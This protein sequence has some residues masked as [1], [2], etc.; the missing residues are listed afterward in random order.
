MATEITAIPNGRVKVVETTTGLVSYFT[1]ENNT[2]QIQGGNVVIVNQARTLNPDYTIDPAQVTTPA[3]PWTAET[4][5]D[6]LNTSP[7]FFKSAGGGG[8]GGIT[9]VD[10]L[11]PIT[12]TG[13]NPDPVRIENGTVDGDTVCWNAGSGFWV[14][15]SKLVNQRLSGLKSGIFNEAPLTDASDD[16]ATGTPT[17]K[18]AHQHTTLVPGGVSTQHING[19]SDGIGGGPIRGTVSSTVTVTETPGGENVASVGVLTLADR[20]AAISQKTNPVNNQNGS[21]SSTWT[22]SDGSTTTPY[23]RLLELFSLASDVATTGNA[24]RDVR[25]QAIAGKHA[26]RQEMVFDRTILVG[27]S[28]AGTSYAALQYSDSVGV[29]LDEY[30][31]RETTDEVTPVT[32]WT[33]PQ[34]AFDSPY[35]DGTRLSVEFTGQAIS[36]L[37]SQSVYIKGICF[38]IKNGGT[39]NWD[40]VFPH[41]NGTYN[42]IHKITNMISD[43][44]FDFNVSSGGDPFAL[45]FD[46]S[47]GSYSTEAVRVSVFVKR[48]YTL[49]S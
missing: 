36:T 18:A 25:P 39:G 15:D 16:L 41:L 20:L 23:P 5:S 13:V 24:R 6:W 35:P 48:I 21:A 42:E 49:P 33:D 11:T 12:G 28:Q 14:I 8:G 2:A 38:Y 37:T 30:C 27:Q 1:N 26:F 17:D 34:D 19:V 10:T 32:V 29:T 47:T 44:T 45:I 43:P 31:D 7:R 40:A 46:P 3:G 4:L 9:S 22:N